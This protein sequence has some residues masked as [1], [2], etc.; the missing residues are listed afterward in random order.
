MSS[1]A[2]EALS[3]CAELR[4]LG[5]LLERPRPGWFDEVAA[6]GREV[7]DPE[8]AQ[9]AALAMEA[10][11]GA[12]LA[13]MGPGGSVSPRAPA[14]RNFEDP[15]RVMAQL[16]A[17]HQAFS[18]APRTEDPADHI[19]SEAS[20]AA[21]LQLKLSY[22]LSEGKRDE[23]AVTREAMGC[24]VKDHLAPLARRFAAR[25]G[26]GGPP[27]LVAAAKLLDAR[28]A[29]IPVESPSWLPPG[30]VVTDAF[31]GCEGCAPST[32]G[33]PASPE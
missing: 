1:E 29:H 19:A 17:L 27:Y 22:A 6:L 3:A 31:D 33:G 28:H 25:L 10:S 21:Y 11:E 12:Y 2:V 8:L 23:A 7:R 14:Y 26:D 4:L 16:A 5:L 32:E 15:A 24:L 20:F 30:A 13:L 18:Y 9:A